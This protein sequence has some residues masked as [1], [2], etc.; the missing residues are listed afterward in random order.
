MDS[1][2]FQFNNG[3]PLERLNS[4][5]RLM[6][7]L[8]AQEEI[9]NEDLD[10]AAELVQLWFKRKMKMHALINKM[11]TSDMQKNVNIVLDVM[12]SISKII[13]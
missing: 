2:I 8:T 1:S 11:I 7:S 9:T 6:L 4:F 5:D 13:N 3:A 12:K 10:S